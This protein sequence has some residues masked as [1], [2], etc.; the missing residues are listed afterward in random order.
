MRLT[1]S[2]IQTTHSGRG[3]YVAD[4]DYKSPIAESD[5]MSRQNSNW[6]DVESVGAYFDNRRVGNSR[7]VENIQLHPFQWIAGIQQAIDGAYTIRFS[8]C[9]L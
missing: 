6:R 5:S 2:L 4:R 3:G 7:K 8:G 9:K 1:F